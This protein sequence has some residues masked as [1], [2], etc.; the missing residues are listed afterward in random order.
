MNWLDVSDIENMSYLFNTSMY[1][2]KTNIYNGDI[3]KWDVSNV[4]NMRS[5]FTNT[6]FNGDISGWNVSNVN[7]MACMF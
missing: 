1:D 4:T 2:D 6:I 7:D 5:M 3:S